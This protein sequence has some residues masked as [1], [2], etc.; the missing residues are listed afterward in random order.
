MT[1]VVPQDEGQSQYV[2]LLWSS[3]APDKVLLLLFFFF[4]Q[5]RS[6]IFLISS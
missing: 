6:D 5:K 3:M 4:Q 2:Q 1:N